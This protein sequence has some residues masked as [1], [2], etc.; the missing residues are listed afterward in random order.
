M[1]SA[2]GVPLLVHPPAGRPRPE[3]LLVGLEHEFCVLDRERTVDFRS[4][5]HRI[6][7][8]G[9]RVDPGDPNAYRCAWGGLITADGNEAEI[10][11][12]PVEL[13]PG[14]VAQV[15]VRAEIARRQ[16]TRALP[17][18]LV[19]RGYSTHLS[20]A[21]PPHLAHRVT[22]LYTRRFAAP[23]M[24]LLDRPQSPG[25]LVR[26][27]PGR[28]ELCGE[29]ATDAA[30]RGASA[31]AAGSVLACARA[32]RDRRFRRMLPAALDTRLAPAAQRTGWFVDRA[33]FG[34]DLY[35]TGRATRLRS[36]RHVLTAQQQLEVAWAVARAELEGIVAPAD[37]ADADDVVRGAVPL[38]IEHE[39]AP[40][41]PDRTAPQP[42]DTASAF[43]AALTHRARPF[44]T[45][46][47]IVVSWDL[48]VFAVHG[49]RPAYIGVP[50]HALVPFLS[51]LDDGHLDADLAAFL[52]APARGRVLWHAA[53]VSEPAVFDALGP[54]DALVPREPPPG[55]PAGGVA[56][57]IKRMQDGG[58]PGRG[59]R[60]D[61]RARDETPRR[62]PRLPRSV[63]IGGLVALVAVAILA[64]VAGATADKDRQE[65]AT[66]RGTTTL[67][68]V[69]AP[70]GP[71]PP[72]PGARFEMSG[73][74]FGNGWAEITGSCPNG[75][76]P[77]Q[78]QLLVYPTMSAPRIAF[79]DPVPPGVR[80]LEMT[81]VGGDHYEAVL[82]A[83]TYDPAQSID[84]RGDCTGATTTPTGVSQID[85][86][87]DLQ[88][89][90]ALD[91]PTVVTL[92]RPITDECQPDGVIVNPRID[93][94]A[95]PDALDDGRSFD[96]YPLVA[97]VP[98]EPVGDGTFR[99]EQPVDEHLALQDGNAWSGEYRCD[100][101]PGPRS[102]PA[103]P[104]APAAG[105]G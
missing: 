69:V 34:T 27:R 6:D 66:G 84:A 49:A 19:L 97:S 61:K 1:R 10:A 21:T 80:A 40:A 50:R 79:G 36:G 41:T 7:V 95:V 54:T 91:G 15:S 5:V 73:G 83:D 22:S 87:M 39:P 57:V 42:V 85:H 47:A 51:R 32:A 37:L 31:F 96:D 64:A 46:E 56:G 78:V 13:A 60:R 67:G 2:R 26:L 71:T 77:G 104:A 53:D 94:R 11:I 38:A 14:F 76:A 62:R 44:G 65:L 20:V 16:L 48:V 75:A 98:L 52:A 68:A 86:D 58:G 102:L 33:A 82:P 70:P 90:E 92:G 59:E 24:M 3:A 81:N 12:A 72:A 28:T 93:Y 8:D 18:P 88:V 105:G 45:V 30:L 74:T 29:Y 89:I 23:F 4:I 63:L 100:F 17:D 55:A 9:R 101:H 25:L 99:V 35:A 43:G 103:A